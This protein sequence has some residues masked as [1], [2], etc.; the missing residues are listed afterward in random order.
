MN[1][2]LNKNYTSNS[3]ILAT[4]F[5]IYKKKHFKQI[6]KSFKKI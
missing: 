3:P 5:F 2:L 6:Q 4:Q 1:N